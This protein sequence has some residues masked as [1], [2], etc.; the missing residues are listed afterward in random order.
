V[1][2]EQSI[3]KLNEMEAFSDSAF[4]HRMHELLWT[5]RNAEVVALLCDEERETLAE[6]NRQFDALPW[7]VIA[8][9]PH[10]SELPDNDLSPLVPSGE[11]LLR[12]LE[13]RADG[14]S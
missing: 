5:L 12:M 9:H 11:R 13:T 2:P 10:I 7:R 3:K 8:D 14:L 4:F 1:R 6:F